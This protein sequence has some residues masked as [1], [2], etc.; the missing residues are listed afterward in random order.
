MV[1][2]M[3]DNSTSR[4]ISKRIDTVQSYFI[5]QKKIFK[6]HG[7]IEDNRKLTLTEKGKALQE[8]LLRIKEILEGMQKKRRRR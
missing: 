1:M 6:A 4:T 3:E 8:N 7:I 2:A 5:K